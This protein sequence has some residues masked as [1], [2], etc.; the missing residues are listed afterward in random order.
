VGKANLEPGYRTI[1]GIQQNAVTRSG[2]VFIDI[3]K[4]TKFGTGAY[5][6]NGSFGGRLVQLRAGDKVHFTKA[7]YDYV[8]SAVLKRLVKITS[9][10]DRRAAL[11]NVELQ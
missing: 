4:L 1:S 6:Q 5:S 3:H 11:K 8:A 2:G 9:E 7:G 10:R